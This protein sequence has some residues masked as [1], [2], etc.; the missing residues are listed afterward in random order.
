MTY[1]GYATFGGTEIINNE[2]IRTLAS[3]SGASWFKGIRY[4]A[5]AEA[6]G[7]IP[8]DSGADYNFTDLEKAPW[9]DPDRPALAAKFFGVYGMEIEGVSDS[10]R[11]VSLTENAGDGGVIGNPR[12]GSRSVRV[13]AFLLAEGTEALTYGRAWLSTVLDLSDCGQGA[14]CDRAEVK[15]YNAVPSTPTEATDLAL[16]LKYA[17]VTS[18]PFTVDQFES[19]G[20]YGVKVEWE[21]TSE[22]AHVYGPNRVVELTTSEAFGLIQDAPINFIP[23]PSAELEEDDS[24][25]ALPLI[26]TNVAENS[27]LESNDTGWTGFATTVTGDSPASYLSTG[28]TEDGSAIGTWAYKAA[29]EGN[30]STAVNGTA[31]L[32]VYCAKSE[33]P[34]APADSYIECAMW[35]T[36]VVMAGTFGTIDSFSVY[37]RWWTSGDVQV[38]SDFT[39]TESPRAVATYVSAK[40]AIPATATKISLHAVADV[41]WKSGNTDENNSDIRVL[42]DAAT[43]AYFGSA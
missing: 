36:A 27:S 2:R 33:F 9:Y 31:L 30:E 21:W 23:Y 25:Y 28:R 18:G 10:T 29:I 34:L 8:N 19:K 20:F 1:G 22:K 11:S 43:I 35:A 12:R 3:S 38:G 41:T 24:G 5:L 7:E 37:G 40:T 13:T 14:D 42:A 16:F 26:A 4:P 15:F 17:A 39:L 32:G 6:L